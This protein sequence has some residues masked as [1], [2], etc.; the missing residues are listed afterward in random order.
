MQKIVL[1]VTTKELKKDDVL[2]YSE[3]N[4]AF[5]N[6]KKDVFLGK[7]NNTIK[8]MQE[9]ITSLK[10]QINALQ[11]KFNSLLNLLKEKL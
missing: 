3:K 7:T 11:D 2:V 1:D 8:S 4:K 5:I 10:T 6:I 9:E